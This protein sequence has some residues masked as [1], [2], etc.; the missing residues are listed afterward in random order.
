VKPQQKID[1]ADKIIATALGERI[2]TEQ[3]LDPPLDNALRKAR[4]R[5]NSLTYK[6][7]GKFEISNVLAAFYLAVKDRP[8][9]SNAK[10]APLFQGQLAA[11]LRGD[12]FSGTLV[13]N[14]KNGDFIAASQ[15]ED[16]TK[17]P[18]PLEGLSAWEFVRVRP[19][20]GKHLLMRNSS[21]KR[22]LLKRQVLA[23]L[24]HS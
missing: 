8:V 7:T 18:R 20:S 17:R 11:F 14:G 4:G 1:S 23:K 2:R 13:R 12:K 6:I 10:F 9:Y 19:L 16:Y 22:R 21:M 24:Y 15:V 3:N 5:L